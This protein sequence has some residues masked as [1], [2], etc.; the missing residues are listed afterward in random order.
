MTP[1]ANQ[2]SLTVAQRETGADKNPKLLLCHLLVS[3]EDEK[4]K[5]QK[6]NKITGESESCAISIWMC[7]NNSFW[8]SKHQPTS[9]HTAGGD[10]GQPPRLGVAPQ[11]AQRENG[12]A[13][14]EDIVVLSTSLGAHKHLSSHSAAENTNNQEK[15]I[16]TGI[17]SILQAGNFLFL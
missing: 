2:S 12:T 16:L 6:E 17:K 4:F 9:A 8:H 14:L 10:G 7:Q 11:K 3:N 15:S 1:G 13:F 5:T